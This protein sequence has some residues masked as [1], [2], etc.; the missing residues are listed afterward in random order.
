MISKSVI[1]T[2]QITVV[3]YQGYCEAVSNIA[4]SK[5]HHSFVEIPVNSNHFVAQ[6]LVEILARTGQI[7]LEYAS[8]LR[9]VD[10]GMDELVCLS[11]GGH[12][13]SCV[14][15]QYELGLPDGLWLCSLQ[16]HL[17]YVVIE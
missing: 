16:C 9:V 1:P 7:Q 17:H 10:S 3:E 2:G 13:Q 11:S 15:L 6:V 14:V 12:I 4:F 5:W 8:A